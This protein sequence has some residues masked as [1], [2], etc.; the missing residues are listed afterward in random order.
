MC[1]CVCV[2]VTKVFASYPPLTQT[3]FTPHI[4]S[5]QDAKPGQL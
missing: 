4:W 5:E 1:V 2:C 3:V